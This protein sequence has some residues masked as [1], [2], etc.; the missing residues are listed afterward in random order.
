MTK[1][2]DLYGHRRKVTI[3]GHTPNGD[4]MF[5][6]LGSSLWRK[7]HD[8]RSPGFFGIGPSTS[9]DS[10]TDID[11]SVG[12]DPPASDAADGATATAA[13]SHRLPSTTRVWR[14]ATMTVI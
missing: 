7:W 12:P 10:D 6:V 4:V 14:G 8:L 13:V 11:P 5:S 3:T 1:E 9:H 2:V